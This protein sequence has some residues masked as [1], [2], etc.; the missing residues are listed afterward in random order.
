MHKPALSSANLPPSCAFA[1][2]FKSQPRINVRPK[3]LQKHRFVADVER[4][5]TTESIQ[6]ILS[7]LWPII[8]GIALNRCFFGTDKIHRKE[9]EFGRFNRYS[10]ADMD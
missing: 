10:V 9:L 8:R 5:L 4:S 7:K 1:D 3:D 2:L 6:W